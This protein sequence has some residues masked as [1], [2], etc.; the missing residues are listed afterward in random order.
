MK[1]QHTSKVLKRKKLACKRPRCSKPAL[2]NNTQ[3]E[4]LVMTVTRA[5]VVSLDRNNV[6]SCGMTTDVSWRFGTGGPT[7]NAAVLILQREGGHRLIS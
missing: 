1:N 2:L 6:S 4:A 5:S 7:R 3:Y